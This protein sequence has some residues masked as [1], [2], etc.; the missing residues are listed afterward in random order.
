MNISSIVVRCKYEHEDELVSLFKASDFCEFH[1]NS[2]K[3]E[4][5]LTI[6]AESVGEEMEI[7]KKIQ[8]IPRVVSAEMV[9]SYAEDELDRER[10]KLTGNTD[11][12]SWLNDE[13]AD[14]RDIKY[15]GDLRKKL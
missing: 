1:L 9:Y 5:I 13:N 4:I 7:L 15:N 6:E 2:R 3:G 11:L 12:P 10:E 14:A 8:Q